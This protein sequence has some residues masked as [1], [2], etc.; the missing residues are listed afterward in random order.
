[1]NATAPHPE[2]P[3]WVAPFFHSREQQL[4]AA[5]LG[6]WLFIGQEILFFS[7]LFMAYIAYRWMYPDTWLSAADELDKSLGTLNTV[8][9]LTSSL[10]MAFGV[11]AL[12]MARPRESIRYLAATVGFGLVFLGIK[13][14]EYA[15]KFEEG[16]LPGTHY[17]ADVV[18]GMAG[19]FFGV[20]FALTG[21]HAAHVIIGLGLLV[22]LIKKIRCGNVNHDN[23]SLAENIGLY[24]HLVDLVW[25][26]L[27]PMLYLV[28]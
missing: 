19:L 23:H 12:R 11:R 27:F 26:F 6:M 15:H 21:L 10:T 3:P 14:V 1:M 18:E 7:G 9:L 28:R 17:N 4:S 8:V 13:S 22:W 20:Y 24:W 5:N 16:L 2:R 25:I